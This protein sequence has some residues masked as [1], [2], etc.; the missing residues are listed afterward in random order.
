VKA[1]LCE[2]PNHWEFS[3]AWRGGNVPSP[4]DTAS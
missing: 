3:S 1:G 2:R 4:G